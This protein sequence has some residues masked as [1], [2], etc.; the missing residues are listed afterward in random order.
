MD[1]KVVIAGDDGAPYL[2]SDA[3]SPATKAFGEIVTAVENRLPPGKVVPPIQMTSQA[4]PQMATNSSCGC[5][6][7]GCD[8]DKCDC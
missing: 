6:D 5:G 1:P 2:S 8:P 4:A 3:D 7:T